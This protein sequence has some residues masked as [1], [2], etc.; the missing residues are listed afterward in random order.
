MMKI[1]NEKDENKTR[2]IL[3]LN[4]VKEERMKKK[5]CGVGRG[6]QE[7]TSWRQYPKIFEFFFFFLFFFSSTPLEAGK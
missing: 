1:G 7:K 6:C 4:W 5:I 2:W 3:G